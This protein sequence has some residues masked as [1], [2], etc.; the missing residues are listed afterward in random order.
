MPAFPILR[1]VALAAAALAAVL[2]TPALA[3]EA[4]PSRSIT[5]IVPFGPGSGGD[6]GARLFAKHL[7]EATGQ[8]VTVEN[9]PGANGAIG[10][11]QAAR[12][13]PDGYTLVIGSATTNAT[14]FAFHGATLPYTPAS[15]DAVA[16][17]GFSPVSLFVG[18]ALAARSVADLAAAARRD[19][20]KVTC[21][22]GNAVT[23]VACEVL[24]RAL[25]VDIVNVPY[26]SNPNSLNDLAGGQISVAFADASVSQPY[27]ARDAIRTIAVASR[28]R[29]ST[30][31]NVPTLAEQGV[32][33]MEITA[34]TALL[35]PA[36]TPMP[37]QERLNAL[38]RRSNDHP[39]SVSIREKTGS[40]VFTLDV[41]GTRR[42]VAE[43]LA[44]WARYVKETGVKA[45]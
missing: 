11:Q 41:A 1:P 10:M 21:G 16:G 8:T 4:W 30:Q 40:S 32:A 17:I 29:M 39:E 23:Q 35:V 12:A 26:K 22:S 33:G 45:E 6:N 5:I 31:P 18:P 20:G 25:G 36:G 24:R 14:N 19:P 27:L 37:I 13:R 42:F 28:E 9:R 34:W 2:A 43:E 7:S 38:V 3:Q 44:R 15:F